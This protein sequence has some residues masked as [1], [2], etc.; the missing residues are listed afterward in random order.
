VTLRSQPSAVTFTGGE[1]S[2]RGCTHTLAAGSGFTTTQV[3]F[4]GSLKCGPWTLSASSMGID[5]SGLAGG[6][7]LS[8]W[9]KSFVMTYAAS[10]EVLSV[11]G[12]LSG[13]DTPWARVPGFEAEYQIG[14]PKLELKLDG[15][16]FSSTFG[17]GKVSV[18]TTARKPDGNPWSSASVTPGTVVV[19]APP[20]N[21]IP[22]PI[23]SLPA[24]MDAEKSA[25]DAC[26]AAARR[27]LVGQALQHALDVCGSSHPSPP[28]GLALPQSVS[29]KIGDVFR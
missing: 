19:P 25:R 17:A 1:A 4:E 9:S 22:V 16:S 20:S 13:A 12:S 3:L 28:S 21:G 10:G 23:P 15:Q 18:R 6:G 24:P 27:T 14:S 29:L 8:T 5:K 11:R 7:T 26:Q 2:F